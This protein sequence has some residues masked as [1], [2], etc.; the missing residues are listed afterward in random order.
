MLEDMQIFMFKRIG[1]DSGDEQY[2]KDAI[3]NAVIPNRGLHTDT[4]E[5]TAKKEEKREEIKIEPIHL[6][7]AI[8]PRQLFDPKNC[9]GIYLSEI[10]LSIDSMKGAGRAMQ[11]PPHSYAVLI[12]KALTETLEGHLSLNGIY[13]WIKMHF[14]YYKTADPAWQNSIRHNLSLNKM[15]EK[16]KRPASEP[17]K[18][19]FW[20]LNPNFE[21][22]KAVR[23]RKNKENRK[24]L[25]AE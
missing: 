16:V 9:P 24:E 22:V 6:E 13:N 15:F 21:P 25:Q 5:Y 19:G 8:C 12:K 11:K 17:G 23:P 10:D 3:D 20:R 4:F 7:E 2:L 1:L 14:P 18:G